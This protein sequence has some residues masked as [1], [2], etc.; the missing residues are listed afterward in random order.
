MY[1]IATNTDTSAS[2]VQGVVIP[3]G[4]NSE[5]TCKAL[6]SVIEGTNFETGKGFCTVHLINFKTG[7]TDFFGVS[8]KKKR[9]DNGVMLNY[10]PFCGG[11]PGTFKG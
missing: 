7:K 5:T 2:D 11:H 8:Y 4:C 6:D 10:C 3:G 9:S 1:D